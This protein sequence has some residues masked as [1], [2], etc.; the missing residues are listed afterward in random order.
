MCATCEDEVDGGFVARVVTTRQGVDCGFSLFPIRL[1]STL[2]LSA[3]FLVG[4]GKWRTSPG[5]GGVV[6][7]GGA[8]AR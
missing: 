5:V 8:R 3:F 4:E 6:L 1:R 7:K 2:V